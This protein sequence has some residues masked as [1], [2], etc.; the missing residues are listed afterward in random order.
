M[1][2]SKIVALV[3]LKLICQRKDCRMGH[4]PWCHRRIVWWLKRQ[5]VRS[6]DTT[7]HQRHLCRLVHCAIYP[8]RAYARR[9]QNHIRTQYLSLLAWSHTQQE[10]ASCT[11]NETYTTRNH[12]PNSTKYQEIPITQTDIQRPMQ[13]SKRVVSK[14]KRVQSLDWQLCAI[15]CLGVLM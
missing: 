15:I 1:R 13:S 4:S 10:S 14:L 7:L 11:D 2:S 12:R 6:L 9:L 5:V 8:T 3:K